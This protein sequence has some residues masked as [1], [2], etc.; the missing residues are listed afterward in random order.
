MYTVFY[1]ANL[2]CACGFNEKKLLKL[3]HY[4][5][6]VTLDFSCQSSVC[7]D[8]IDVDGEEVVS[9]SVLQ[10]SAE[11]LHRNGVYLMDHGKVCEPLP[12]CVQVPYFLK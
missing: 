12:Q 11:K 4:V 10:L 3:L 9:P 1:Y 6:I 7:Q 2:H 5:I 8:V